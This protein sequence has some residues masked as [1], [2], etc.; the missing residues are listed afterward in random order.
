[1]ILG[2]DGKRKIRLRRK[3]NPELFLLYNDHLSLRYRS[4]DALEEAIIILHH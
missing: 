2:T 4:E 1:M 3:T